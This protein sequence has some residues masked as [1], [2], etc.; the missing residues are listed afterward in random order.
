MVSGHMFRILYE[1]L[2]GLPM[3]IIAT[4]IAVAAAFDDAAEWLATKVPIWIR[5]VSD[6]WIG[7]PVAVTAVGYLIAL[8]WTGHL[9]A[10]VRPRFRGISRGII[11]GGVAAD[12]RSLLLVELE[13]R[14]IGEM[15][16]SAPLD[17]W[18]MVLRASEREEQLNITAWTAPFSMEIGGRK[19]HF[20]PEG[21]IYRKMQQPLE[22]GATRIGYVSANITK[23][24]DAKLRVGA[25]VRIYFCDAFERRYCVEH[26][27]EK[28]STETVGYLETA[29]WDRDDKQS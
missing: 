13:V 29:G 4:V 3:A 12:G 9:A 26:A 16:S 28:P 5:Q 18:R 17:S 15:A 8:L 24:Q 27:I 14:N 19:L 11:H 2:R 23:E 20:D 1:I 22:I 25:G 7:I 6:P 10:R 21:A